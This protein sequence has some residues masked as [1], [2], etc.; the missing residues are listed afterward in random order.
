MRA[1]RGFGKRYFTLASIQAH[2]V[3]PA[4][5]ALRV[6]LETYTTALQRDR[7]SD[8]EPPEEPLEALACF[9]N[10]KPCHC[11]CYFRRRTSLTLRACRKKSA[12]NCNCRFY[13][14]RRTGVHPPHL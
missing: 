11:D 1:P 12:C 9:A 7:E 14:F 6:C 13:S 8:E 10:D 2:S 4:Q 3:A 5:N